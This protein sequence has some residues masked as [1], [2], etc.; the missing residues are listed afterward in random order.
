MAFPFWVLGNIIGR[1]NLLT[2]SHGAVTY[3]V[4][5]WETQT[6]YKKRIAE[7]KK[8]DILGKFIIIFPWAAFRAFLGFMQIKAFKLG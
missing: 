6:C 2:L 1:P 4:H 8:N 5:S 7:T 3:K